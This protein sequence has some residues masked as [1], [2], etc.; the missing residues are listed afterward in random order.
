MLE[1]TLSRRAGSLKAGLQQRKLSTDEALGGDGE[2]HADCR[3]I[4]DE[5]EQN[6]RHQAMGAKIEV[7]QGEGEEEQGHRVR[8]GVGQQ[9]PEPF[10]EN[11]DGND[12]GQECRYGEL[13]VFAEGIEAKSEVGPS[14]V[15]EG[16]GGRR[17]LLPRAAS[18]SRSRW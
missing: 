9:S 6:C 8:D 1:F 17:S 14:G 3:G 15:A 11:V 13:Q 2:E 10:L 16:F 4:E 5:V 7:A 12:D 18:W